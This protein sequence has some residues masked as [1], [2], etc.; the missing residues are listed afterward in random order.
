MCQIL[1]PDSK[2]FLT[3]DLLALPVF[4]HTIYPTQRFPLMHTISQQSY[5]HYVKSFACEQ[6]L[7][8]FIIFYTLVPFLK[9]IYFVIT[10]TH[11]ES[12]LLK[13]YQRDYCTS[14]IYIYTVFQ[15][16]LKTFVEM[17]IQSAEHITVWSLPL[18]FTMIQ[19]AFSSVVKRI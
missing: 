2:V 15:G 10:Y 12:G 8:V 9:R 18:Q 17:G 14:L 19:L 11:E 4:K 1:E 5:P 16:D 3:V 7:F 13:E 6:L